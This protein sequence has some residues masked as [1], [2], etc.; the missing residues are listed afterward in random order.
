MCC[1]G[2]AVAVLTDAEKRKNYD[3][4]GSN[5]ERL[6]NRSHHTHTYETDFTAE[7]MFNMF[8]GNGLNGS[9][10][11]YRRGNRW[12]RHA[13]TTQSESRQQSRQREVIKM[14]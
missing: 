3:L 11:Y 2:N 5:E 4:Y 13:S 6:P 9:N 12:Q 8:F 1:L 14:C 7:E 10:I